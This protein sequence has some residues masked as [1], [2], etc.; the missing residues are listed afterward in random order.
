LADHPYRMQFAGDPVPQLA[1]LACGW[2]H[3]LAVFLIV[4]AAPA[5][6]V[7]LCAAARAYAGRWLMPTTILYP[8]I[9]YA[10]SVLCFCAVDALRR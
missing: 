8:A 1:R 9:G 10:V 2:S 3:A 6:L 7:A 5:A 4:G